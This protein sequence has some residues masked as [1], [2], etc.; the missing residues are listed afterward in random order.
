[1]YSASG[2]QVWAVIG[3]MAARESTPAKH[4]SRS[5]RR[6]AYEPRGMVRGEELSGGD[7]LMTPHRLARGIDRWPRTTSARIFPDTL[8]L[9]AGLHG[10]QCVNDFMSESV[11]QPVSSA[12]GEDTWMDVQARYISLYRQGYRSETPKHLGASGGF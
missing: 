7:C 11:W 10:I 4:R 12:A 1:M 3:K 6:A 5:V 2:I 8:A 9:A